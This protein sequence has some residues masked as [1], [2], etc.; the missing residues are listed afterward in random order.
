LFISEDTSLPTRYILSGLESYLDDT[1]SYPQ[2]G[3]NSI[4]TLVT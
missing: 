4:R 1:Y 2:L 3:P